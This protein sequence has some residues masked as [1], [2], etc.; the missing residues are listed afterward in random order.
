VF[1][2]SEEGD[3]YV[4]Q[5]GSEYKLLGKN[6]LNDMALATPAIVRGSLIIRTQSKLFR[7]ANKTAQ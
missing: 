4:I 7:I 2:L 6:S 5:A 1:L 3:T